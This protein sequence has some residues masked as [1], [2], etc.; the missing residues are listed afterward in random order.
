MKVRHNNQRTQLHNV[1]A[2]YNIHTKQL[3]GCAILPIPYKLMNSHLVYSIF[4][5]Y[6]PSYIIYLLIFMTH[7]AK[8]E[9]DIFSDKH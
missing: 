9:R 3:R 1:G 8:S 2:T 5:R 6:L 4:G 7:I